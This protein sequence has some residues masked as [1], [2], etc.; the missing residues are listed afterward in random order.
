LLSLQDTFLALQFLDDPSL[1]YRPNLV[2]TVKLIVQNVAI[3]HSICKS[4]NSECAPVLQKNVQ[5]FLFRIP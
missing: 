1:S 3:Q 4:E 2:K 5:A